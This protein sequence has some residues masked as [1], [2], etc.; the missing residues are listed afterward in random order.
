MTRKLLFLVAAFSIHVHAQNW[1]TF[2]DPSRAINWTS[3][4]FTIPNYTTNCPTQPTLVA[5]SGNA[6]ANAT[7]IQNALASC[8][9]TQ[10]VVNLPAGTYYVTSWTYGSQGHQVVRGA[11][12]SLTYLYMTS[13]AG[14]CTG[15]GGA[16]CMLGSPGNYNGSPDVLP[17]NGAH[18]CQWSAGYSQGST[19]ITLTNCGGTPPVNQTIILDQANDSTDSGGISICDTSSSYN[20]TYKGIGGGNNVGRVINGVSHSQQQVAYVTGVTSLGNGSYT[21]TISPG[22]YFSNIRSSQSPGAWWPGFVQNDGL[23]NLTVDYSQS[24]GGATTA[25]A[26]TMFDCY[27]CW[28]KNIR[29]IDA[30]RN[31][32]YVIQ[33][34]QDVIRDSYFY[35]SQSHSSVSYTVEVEESSGGLIENN[36]MQQVTNP[37]MFGQCSGFVVGYNF[38]ID[39]I[40]TGADTFASGSYAG[41]N[42]G[43]EMNLWEGNNFLGIWVDD[44]WG[45]SSQSTLYRNLLTGW[46]NGKT[47]ATMPILISAWSRAYNLVGNVLGQP[48]YHTVYQSYAT[49]STAGVNGGNGNTVIYNLGWSGTGDTCASGAPP[50]DSLTYPTTMRWGNW[51]V[52]NSSSQWNA[53][54]AAPAAVPYLNAN[55]TTSYFS[56]LSHTLPAS[57]YN[58]STPSWWPS[59]KAWPPVG[60]DVSS[61]NLGICSGGTYAGAMATASSQCSGGSLKSAW[62]GTANS[63]PAQDC[64]LK[65]MGGAPDGTGNVLSFDANT[66]YYG[67]SMVKPGS[68]TGL[69]GTVRKTSN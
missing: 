27:E 12:P 40:Y 60:P 67:S 66:C 57:L 35:Q 42:A 43:N 13:G 3:A 69:T 21:V 10:N 25:A 20:C 46:Q 51:D 52:V 49:S 47:N 64:Y 41:H 24:T 44:A 4:G 1:S 54:E 30:A 56:S 15:D 5:G 6:A 61:G 19:T 50:C 63:T 33:S 37:L 36:I 53:T 32:V 18:Q 58:I 55:F 23:E 62:A 9:A 29:S 14:E 34:G 48:G 11:G 65:T 2:L 31:H 28:I 22:V 16:I 68:P 38:G 39:D 17:S 26:I 45:S 7:A 59:S 8:T